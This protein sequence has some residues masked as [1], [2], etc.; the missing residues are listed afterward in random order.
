MVWWCDGP[1]DP[2]LMVDTLRYFSVQS[3]LHDWYNKGRGMCYP[4]CGMVYIKEP[5]LLIEKE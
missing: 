4:L 5:L 2:R 3:V 1:S